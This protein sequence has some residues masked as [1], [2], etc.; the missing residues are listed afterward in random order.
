MSA[1]P[2]WML[3]NL[4]LSA[5]GSVAFTLVTNYGIYAFVF[6]SELGRRLFAGR[7]HYRYEHTRQDILREIRRCLLPEMF[8]ALIVGLILTSGAESPLKPWLSIRWAM[9]A[10]QIP[11][12]LA[13]TF[14]LF[15][16]YEIYYF[17]LHRAIHTRRFYPMFHSVH[18]QSIYP[19]PFSQ[20]SVNL[21]EAVSFYSFYLFALFCPLHIVSLAAIGISIKL[22][23]LTQHL[24]HECFPRIF[25]THRW[26][27]YVNSTRYHQLHH[28]HSFKHNYGF[29]TSVLDRLFGTIDPAY[30]EYERQS[31]EEG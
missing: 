14:G 11:S 12:I 28:S 4:L 23:S 31:R 21:M 5:I 10:S 17:F 22:G 2:L 18:H 24:G 27:K 8:V 29:Q 16:A 9:S 1:L 3:K 6:H 13:E 19:T 15:W 30:L 25:R 20:T 7:K 26:L